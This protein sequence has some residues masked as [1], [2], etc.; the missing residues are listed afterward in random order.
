M[1]KLI[2]SIV[3]LITLL[4][5][6]NQDNNK[7]NQLAQQK[8]SETFEVKID[9]LLKNYSKNNKFMGSLA[10]S[11]NGKTIYE[12]VV[13][14]SN[15]NTK[16]S[17]DVNTKYRIGS[18][19]KVFTAVLIF[20]AVEENKLQLNHTIENDF[21]NVKNASKITIAHLLQHRSGIHSFTKDKNFFDYRTT[22]KSTSEMLSMISNYESDFEPNSKGS[23]SNSNYFLL[24][25]LLEKAYNTSYDKLLQE[26]I[27]KPLQLNNTFVGKGID[28]NNNECYSYTF[29]KEWTEFPETHLSITKGSGSIISTP[30]D[31]NKFIEA[32]FFGHLVSVEHLEL[33]KT[34]KEGFGMGLERFKTNDRQGFG[35]RGHIDG[36]RSTT[37]YF[38]DEKLSFSLT[39]NASKIDIN[40]IY[41]DILK[42]YFSDAIIEI[43][44]TE[45]QKFT[46]TYTSENNN[47]DKLVFTQDKTTLIH[48]IKNEFEEPLIYKGSNRFVMEQLYA[49]SM[50]FTFSTDGKQ[51]VLAQGESTWNYT[52]EQ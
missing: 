27:C 17:A 46:G 20:K 30:K 9:N 4:W 15:T 5:S 3:V 39:S 48:V 29:D 42:L 8:Q 21:P 38:P 2:L 40:I 44:E 24:S 10:L 14:F 52:K 35:H 36:F 22:E 12:A 33:M 7:S 43:P 51:L 11:H 25:L 6:C 37:I 19:S 23:Y 50:S 26:K 13:G 18:I 34:I 47:T 45:V 41:S 28:I 1:K 49:E 31:I 32:L 16:K